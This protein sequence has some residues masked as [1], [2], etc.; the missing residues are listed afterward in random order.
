MTMPLL[1]ALIIALVA[2]IAVFAL[3]ARKYGS[4]CIP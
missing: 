1:L 4:D 2:G 3:L